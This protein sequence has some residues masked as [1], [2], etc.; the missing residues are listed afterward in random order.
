[1]ISNIDQESVTM[2]NFQLGLKAIRSK[3]PYIRE[4]GCVLTGRGDKEK[5]RSLYPP[6]GLMPS[7]EK[8]I[9]KISETFNVEEYLAKD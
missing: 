4:L 7:Q 8:L 2:T 9:S 5:L 6:I 3:H 1:M